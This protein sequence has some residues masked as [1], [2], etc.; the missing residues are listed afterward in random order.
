MSLCCRPR[1]LSSCSFDASLCFVG[2]S[3]AHVSFS[4]DSP[5]THDFLTVDEGFKGGSKFFHLPILKYLCQLSREHGSLS[6]VD[7]PI[8]EESIL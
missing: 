8:V 2:C 7:A 4:F 3:C 1:D 5:G 6:L